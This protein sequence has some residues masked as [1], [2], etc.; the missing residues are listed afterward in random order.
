MARTMQ[1]RFQ[2]LSAL[3]IALPVFGTP[4]W[5]AEPAQKHPDVLDV[6]VRV[7]G[8]DR[9]DF[10]VTISSPYDLPERYADAF[11]VIGKEDGT[12]YGE[13]ELLHDHAAEQPFTRD[14]YAVKVPRAV[15]VVVVQGRDQRYGYGGK[16]VEVALPGR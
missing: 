3:V 10:A 2:I 12:V 14:L 13:R 6:K 7:S 16:T 4:V 8:P 15:K 11:R 5:A 9:F 1:R